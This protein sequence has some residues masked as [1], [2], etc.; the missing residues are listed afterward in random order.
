[1]SAKKF[2]QEIY[3]RIGKYIDEYLLLE[4]LFPIRKQAHKNP[5]IKKLV[6][7]I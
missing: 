7:Y 3:R 2:V 6:D 4:T 1:M 5:R